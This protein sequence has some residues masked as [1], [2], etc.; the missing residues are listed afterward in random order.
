MKPLSEF[1]TR[2]QTHVM[3]CPEPTILQA[4]LDTCIAFAE[5]TEVLR[6]SLDPITTVREQADYEITVPSQTRIG[7]FTQIY[8]DGLQGTLLP[9]EMASALR[10]GPARPTK[11]FTRRSSGQF[12]LTMD[13]TPD[14][15]YEVI[16]EAI[17]V[18][19]RNATQVD[20]DFLELW[21]DGI[22][23]G[24]V[25]R[26]KLQKGNA[27]TDEMGAGMHEAVYR[28]EVGRAE[29]EAKLGRVAGSL[30]VTMKPLA[31]G[32]K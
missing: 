7:R 30:K 8:I 27:W 18:P 6:E 22:V 26:L 31:R 4:T 11:A 25:A 13:P 2:I 14:D 19:L 9:R 23:N 21:M 5:E 16:L 12:F 29:R 28:T 15:A 20:D 10:R 1:L 17:L 3:N 24:T 32:R